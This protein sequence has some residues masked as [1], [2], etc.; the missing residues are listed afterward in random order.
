M[1]LPPDFRDLFSELDREAV[2]YVLVGGWAVAFHGRPRATKDIDFVLRGTSENLE[3]AARAL[4]AFGAPP[5]L[6][7]A[8][9]AMTDVDVVFMGH[10]PLRVDFLRS[11]SGVPSDRLFANAERA[12]VGGTTLRVA[13]LDDLIAN[14]R[15]VGRPQDLID[16]AFLERV[17]ARRK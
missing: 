9:R 11:I 8:V 17:R 1:D 12:D 7:E 13:S 6:C 15:S 3:R 5:S 4:E 2:E 16:V 10:P 14:K